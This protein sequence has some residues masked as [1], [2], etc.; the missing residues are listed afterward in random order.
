[1]T[2][3]LANPSTPTP[4]VRAQS[5]AGAA[6]VSSCVGSASRC[7]DAPALLAY[8]HLAS[9]DAPTVAVVWALAFAWA[10]RVTL[11]GWTPA[12]LALV[13]WPVYIADRLLDVRSAFR[14]AQA[15]RL[16]QRHYFHW[17]FR[18]LFTPLGLISACAAAWII[19]VWMPVAIRERNSILAAAG[20]AYFSSVHAGRSFPRILSRIFAPLLAKETLVALIFTAAC[21]LP[22]LGRATTSSSMRAHSPLWSLIPAILYFTILALLNCQSIERWES[23]ES[24]QNSLHGSFFSGFGVF[25]FAVVLGLAGLVLAVALSSNHRIALLVA[26][27]AVAALL[28]AVLDRLRGRLTPLALRAAA[29]L[30]LLT[31]LPFLLR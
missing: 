26:S 22:A 9:L 5:A 21:A 29:D 12:L 27:G 31:P 2:Q 6:R 3:V 1:M 8:W 24:G 11:P 30:V 28:L 16:R 14:T 13:A 15:D 10:A 4:K 17:Q 20:L 23:S 19:V 18:Q 7:F 25:P